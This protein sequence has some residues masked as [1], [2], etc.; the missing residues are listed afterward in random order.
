MK[1]VLVELLFDE[2]AHPT[3]ESTV[4]NALKDL[5]IQL[6]IMPVDEKVNENQHFQVR[7][8]HLSAGAGGMSSPE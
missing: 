2:T 8:D 6:K 4:I 3:I 7:P 5:G 1:K